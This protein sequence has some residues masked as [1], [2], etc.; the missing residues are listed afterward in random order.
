MKFPRL[1]SAFRSD[2]EK[3]IP[4][5]ALSS[6]GPGRG[7]FR[8]F[9]SFAGAWQQNVTLDREL[10]LSYSAVFSCITLISSDISKLRIK[11]VEFKPEWGIW[12]ETDSPA[13]SP[14]LTKPNHFQNRIQF[15]EAW[16]ISK[17]VHGNAYILKRR[18]DRRVVTEL[19]VLDPTRV[20][21]MV[22]DDGSIF[23]RLSSDNLADI[24]GDVL[25]PAYDIIHDRF[26]CFYHPLIGMSPLYASSVAATQGLN[27]QNNSAT[28]FG[29]RSQPGGVLTAP[30]SID[31]TTA[32]RLKEYWDGNFTGENAGK[33]A[34]LGDGLTFSAIGVNAHDSQLIEQLRWSAQIVCSTFHVPPYKIGVGEM[35]K[36][37]NIQMLNVE[38]YQQCLQKLIEDIELCLDEG[39]GLSAP[40]STGRILGTEFDISG[41]LRMDSQS[42]IE[43]LGAGVNRSLIAPNEGRKELGLR[44]AKGGDSPMSQEQNYSLEALAKRDAQDDPFASKNPPEPKPA[45]EPAVNDN[46]EAKNLMIEVYKGLFHG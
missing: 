21:P 18:D 41:L 26:N 37:D 9:E 14:V 35:P 11:L 42:Q 29:N 7:F 2:Q 43:Y 34:V 5:S 28:F 22:A 17:L 27:I 10:I 31:D 12:E 19:Y 39:L 15:I 46:A 38:Y 20:M 24:P 23:Y 8:I 32:A 40:V 33:I 6:V 3:A 36:Y 30:G 4:T 45:P 1:F 13:Y 16:I 25:V 44:P